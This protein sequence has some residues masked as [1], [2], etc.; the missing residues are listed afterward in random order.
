MGGAGGWPAGAISARERS[1]KILKNILLALT[2]L[3]KLPKL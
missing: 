3:L 1:V 2:W